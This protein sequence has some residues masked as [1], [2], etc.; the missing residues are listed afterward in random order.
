MPVI[1][2]LAL[3]SRD[4]FGYALDAFRPGPVETGYVEGRNVA[5]EYR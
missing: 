3:S 1:G 4:T 2:L 5:I